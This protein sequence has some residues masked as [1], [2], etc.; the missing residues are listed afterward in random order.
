MA[1]YDNFKAA[2]KEGIASLE[3]GAMR[4]QKSL[5]TFNVQGKAIAEENQPTNSSPIDYGTESP[6]SIKQLNEKTQF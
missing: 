6:S 2:T 4:L 3:T 1:A 5:E